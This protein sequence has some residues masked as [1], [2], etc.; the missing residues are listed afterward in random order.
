MANYDIDVLTEELSQ[1]EEAQK[2]TK[3]KHSK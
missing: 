3:E 1:L 2:E